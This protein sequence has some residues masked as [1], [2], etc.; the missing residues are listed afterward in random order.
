MTTASLLQPLCFREFLSTGAPASFGTVT[1]YA[2]G[3]STPI[4]T[5]TDSTAGTP[6][7]NPVVLDAR[8]EAQIWTL[9]NIAYKF[10][11]QDSAGNSIRTVDQVQQ[12]QL[13]TLY[14]GVDT[15]APNSYILT[16]TASFSAYANGILIYWIP[17]NNNTGAS[18]LNV[19]GLGAVA[20][21]NLDGSA[22]GAN[23]IVAGVTTAV[24]YYGSGFQLLT[25]GALTGSIIGTFGQEVPLSS[26]STV[27]LGTAP[28]HVAQ[29][30]GTTTITSFGSSA[31]ILAPIYAIRFAASLTLTYNSVSM[32]LPGGASIVTST[33]DTAL[34]QYLGSG[35]WKVINYQSTGGQQNSKIKPSDTVLISN[36]TLTPDP[37][38][39][40]NTLGIGRYSYELYLEFDSVAGGAGFKFTNDGTLVDSRATSPAI[41]YGY[42]NSA[43]YG[44]KNDTFYSTTVSYATVGT[45][46]NSNQVVYKGSLLVSTP[47]TFGISWAQASS[48]ASATTL[49]A[50]SYLVTTLLNTGSAS[51]TI[52]RVY[53][54]PGTG[55]ETIPNGY[56][57]LTIEVWGG[58][59]GGGG[60]TNTLPNGVGGGGGGSG[61]YSRSSISITGLGGDTLNY[62][63]GAAGIPAGDG[64][65]SNVTSGTLVITTMTA[66][67]GKTGVSAPPAGSGGLGGTAT[68]GTVINT[69][70]NT[71]QAG[72]SNP[73]GGDPGVGAF[74]IP[75]IYDGG[76]RGGTGGNYAHL[77]GFAGGVGI[78]VFSYQ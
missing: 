34:V 56:T 44:P 9:P 60:G 30:T 37:D 24:M 4:A 20:I 66:N 77:S 54:T 50:G 5:Y 74:G 25:T 31:S 55:L 61:G 67:G 19:N 21:T 73:A 78:V 39:Q 17:A 18:T 76:N 46:A 75:G 14:G 47:G 6:N 23:Q 65:A 11:V 71:G 12:S 63:V 52:T 42:V 69:S 48:T 7:S 13:L 35:N 43:A 10:V 64:G 2:A 40:T 68:G 3:T 36:A 16:F 41:A 59:G 72:L 58:S 28:A 51:N 29:I 27:D 22:L 32:I 26:A 70:G 45:V 8:G 49:R 57:T 53:Q 15:G 33:G 38:L 62:T 1:S